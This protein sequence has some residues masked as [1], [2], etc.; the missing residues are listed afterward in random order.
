MYEDYNAMQDALKKIAKHIETGGI[1]DEVKPLVFGVT[2]TGR[3]SQGILEVL[4]QFPHDKVDPA[5]LPEFYENYDK[6]KDKI[7][8]SVFSSKD[9]VRGKT[10]E[11]RSKPFDKAHYYENPK[12]YENKFHDMLPYIKFLIAG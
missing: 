2:G 8:I 3:V 12:E 9:L 10:E 5:D 1:P 4:E 11:L 7:V 6:S